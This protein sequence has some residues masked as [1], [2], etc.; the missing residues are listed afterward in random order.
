MSSGVEE[1]QRLFD[2]GLSVPAVDVSG[3]TW[4]EADDARFSLEGFWWR[5][6]GG[7]FRR[8][9]LSSAERTLPAGV[10]GLAWHSSGGCLRFRSDCSRIVVRARMASANLIVRM[11][12]TGSMGFD[13]YADGTCRG[14]SRFRIGEGDFVAEVFAHGE[15]RMRD[16]TL[17]FPT[18]ARLTS[19][20]LGFDAQARFEEPC[21]WPDPRPIVA[22][23]TSIL[24]GACANRPGM[25]Y[26]N[27]LSRTLGRPVLN[28]GFAGNGRGEAVMAET[29][30]EIERP[31]PYLLDYDAN[32]S[33]DQLAATLTPFCRILRAAHPETPI[34]T[35]SR[36]P[37]TEDLPQ[38]PESPWPSERLLRYW[39]IHRQSRDELRAGGDR[40]VH[41]LDGSGL[42]G[43]DWWD[44][45]VD[46]VHLTD[47][48][49]W[50]LVQAIAPE[51]RRI[52]D[53]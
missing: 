3:L 10:D 22:Y 7:A 17:Y 8:L 25:A 47:L 33:H 53:R 26:T 9:P 42:L 49:Y 52:L 38:S 11:A 40:R 36:T 43:A 23:G 34:L 27:L 12:M 30:A 5:R 46:G 50:R 15:R 18:Y 14:V 16:F 45:L 51:I 1:G 35:L 44:C 37:M 41:C 29:L 32:V 48:G 39:D 6:P 4:H 13:L 21:A 20:E 28:Y 19:L 2:P 24:Q 31:A